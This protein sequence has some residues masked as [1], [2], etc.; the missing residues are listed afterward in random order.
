M[1][2]LH[3]FVI[4]AGLKQSKQDL[5]SLDLQPAQL[6]DRVMVSGKRAG[7]VRY[8]GETR[9]APGDLKLAHDMI[10]VL[11][12]LFIDNIIFIYKFGK[13]IF[14]EYPLIFQ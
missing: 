14:H 8:I 7:V 5:S 2:F 1:C 12:N 4:V 11:F 9:F 10:F 3:S 6:D 13:I